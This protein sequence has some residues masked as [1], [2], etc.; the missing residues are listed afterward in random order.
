MKWCAAG[1]EVGGMGSI[2]RTMRAAASNREQY[3]GKCLLSS[4]IA[5]FSIGFNAV[6]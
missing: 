1:G 4:Y 2:Y 3:V 5:Q 6:D